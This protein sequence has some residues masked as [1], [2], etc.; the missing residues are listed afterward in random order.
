VK[1]LQQP[2]D[3]AKLPELLLEY[4]NRLNANNAAVSSLVQSQVEAARRGLELLDKSHRHVLKLRTCMDKIHELCEECSNLIDNHEKIRLLSQTHANLTKVLAETKDIIDLPDR[5]ETVMELMEADTANIL[6]AYEAL[7]VLEGIAENAKAAWK[8][9]VKAKDHDMTSMMRYIERV[10]DVV[11][12]FEGLLWDHLY[13]YEDLAQS[14]PTLLVDCLRV[15]E[16][17]ERLDRQ[18]ARTKMEGLP[19]KKWKQRL[20]DMLK[21]HVEAKFER[22][23]ELAETCGVANKTIKYTAAGDIIMDD[24]RDYMGNLVAVRLMS[25]QTGKESIITDEAALAAL[26]ITEEEVFEEDEWLNEATDELYTIQADLADAYD[27]VAPCFP[28]KYNIFE[29]LFFMYHLQVAIV[30]DAIGCKAKSLSTKGALRVMEFVRKYMETLRG[31]GVEEALVRLPVSPNADPDMPP[32]LD[33]LMDSYIQRME[34]TVTSWYNNIL[35]VDLQYE[36]KPGPNGTLRTP[37]VTDF[38]RIMNEEIEII[39]SMD[40]HGEVMYQTTLMALR[41]MRGFQAAQTKVISA[42]DKALSFEMYCALLNNNVE[43]HDQSLEF[44]EDAQGQLE[45]GYREKLDVEDVCR[46]FLDV[47]RVA[48]QRCVETMFNDPGMSTHI[49][50]LYS[51]GDW[52]A[53]KTTATILA[54]VADYM[55]DVQKFVEASFVKRVAEAALEELVR[56]CAN[57]YVAGIPPVTDAL[58][59][60]MRQDEQDVQGY[61]EG[62]LKADKMLRHMGLLGDLRVLV[63]G[64]SVEAVAASYAN[65]LA[66]YPALTVEVMA[67]VQEARGAFGGWE[68]KHVKDVMALCKDKYAAAQKAKAQA[69][70]GARKEEPKKGGWFSRG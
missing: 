45:E 23:T 46:G 67:R 33:L 1:L 4:E 19:P 9:N 32:G 68:K 55:A 59:A 39:R 58:V 30:I 13:D 11:A 34:T 43:C 24:R 14:S 48:A 62:L 60:R 7:T 36:P 29:T 61:F 27:Y 22:L 56:R 8:R 10:K 6:P 38:F 20:M 47:A 54:T 12:E 70:A 37:G 31:L 66:V 35:V 52:L 16:V 26:D 41:I 49:K 25:A 17:Q 51:P 18:L 65:L 40:D 21:E 50:A 42:R 69:A 44:V 3:L 2:E 64:N 53:G 28:P 57:M 63:S 15:I 5:A